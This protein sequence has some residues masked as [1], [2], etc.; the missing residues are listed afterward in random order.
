[1]RLRVGRNLV[2]LLC[3]FLQFR[4]NLLT[5][6]VS[7]PRTCDDDDDSGPQISPGSSTSSGSKCCAVLF[8]ASSVAGN[9]LSCRLAHSTGQFL[10]DPH[11]RVFL[12]AP[13]SH[14]AQVAQFQKVFTQSSRGSLSVKATHSFTVQ[15]YSNEVDGEGLG[16]GHGCKCRSI[17]SDRFFGTR[18]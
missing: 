13:L 5:V 2:P 10:N 7:P 6:K 9:A 8:I 17:Y 12:H 14:S 15:T 4:L 3:V 16:L 1:M 11:Y 18:P